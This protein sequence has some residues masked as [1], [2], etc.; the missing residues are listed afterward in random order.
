MPARVLSASDFSTLT[1]PDHEWLIPGYLPKPGLL[2]ILGEPRAGKSF[3]ALQLALSLAQGTQFLP[4][5]TTGHTKP[6]KVLYFYFDKT[7]IFVFQ[8]RLKALKASGVNITGPLY[9]VHPLDKIATA[10]L[11]D[12]ECYR[13]FHDLIAQVEPDAVVFDVLREFHNEDEN[14]S[15]AMK[16][17]GDLIARLCEG[18]SIILV[19]HTKKL[20]YPGRTGPVR[21]VEASRG[22]NYIVGKA[23]STWLIHEGHL[24]V[25]SNF[26][27]AVRYRL[28]RN[29]NGL[30]T[31]V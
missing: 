17:V 14:E 31:L 6:K 7:G 20:D 13:Y 22:S 28:L 3:L 2:M 24:S 27:P 18:L 11:L 8:D 29:P 12:L 21:N 4:Q 9:M 19:H 1:L 10:N 26:A 23:D 16:I 30:W 5:A 15:T 25:E